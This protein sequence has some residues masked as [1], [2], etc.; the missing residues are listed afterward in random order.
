MS[1]SEGRLRMCS[2]L[3]K[4]LDS[5]VLVGVQI[6]E[7]VLKISDILDFA[8]GAVIDIPLGLQGQLTLFLG[9]T[10]IAEARLLLDSP[11]RCQL[12]I[13]SVFTREETSLEKRR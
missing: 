13:L 4:V 10:P 1:L 9:E 12:E 2:A 3:S 8:P 5:E 6:A 11:D 7:V